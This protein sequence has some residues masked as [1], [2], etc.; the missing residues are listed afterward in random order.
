MD[1]TID[2]TL[3]NAGMY[4][5]A[6]FMQYFLGMKP[7]KHQLEIGKILDNDEQKQISI[8]VARDHGKSTIATLAYPLRLICLNPNLRILI[9]QKTG[10]SAIKSLEFIKKHL[11]SNE[12]IKKWYAKHWKKLTGETDI[13]NKAGQTKEKSGFWQQRRIYVKRSIISKDPSI[14]TVGIGGTITGGRAD[15]IIL[16]DILDDENTKTDSRLRDIK[17]W[18]EGTVSQLGEPWTKKV[19]IGTPK[20]N[21]ED[22]IYNIIQNNPSWKTYF[23]PALISPTFDE[24][25]YDIIKNDDGIVKGVNVKNKDKIKTLWPSKWDIESLLNEYVSSLD[26]AIWKREKLLDITALGGTIFN[27]ANFNHV[28]N[29]LIKEVLSN[30]ETIIYAALDSAWES[31]KDSDY[32]A[33]IIAAKLKHSVYILECARVKLKLYELMDLLVE[34]YME[35]NFHSLLIEEAASGRALIQM[36]EKET[37]LYVEAV[38][39]GGKNKIQRARTVSPFLNQGRVNLPSEAKWKETFLNEI[40]QFPFSSHD[41]I[42]DSFVYLLH[43]LF[44]EHSLS[45]GIHI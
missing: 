5:T 4:S 22:D 33:L 10:D 28:E 26:Q 13:T 9:V 20:T 39:H 6:I 11:E 43:K 1:K 29:K 14:E 12:I 17:S 25:E 45:G 34:K 44:V 35:Y 32:S 37:G 16:D 27:R 8:F 23:M 36:L 24:I 2:K 7:A 3:A 15:I 41:D 42:T 31:K 30:P 21:N 19:V 40:T 18:F 38:S